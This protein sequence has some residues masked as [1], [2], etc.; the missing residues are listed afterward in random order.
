MHRR[1]QQIMH[2][3]KKQRQLRRQSK[4]LYLILN[5]QQNEHIQ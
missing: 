3:V 4:S 2:Q 5:K 1:E